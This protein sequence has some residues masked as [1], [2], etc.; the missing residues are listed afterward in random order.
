EIQF[1]DS[2]YGVNE[3]IPGYVRVTVLY[4][5][6]ATA[7]VSVEYYTGD[8]SASTDNGD[9]LAAS[10]TLIFDVGETSKTFD[11]Q[12]ID[13]PAADGNRFFTVGLRSPDGAGL[14]VFS[15]SI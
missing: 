2:S 13:N 5:G 15:S 1:S 7:P 8:G 10:G 9:Y 4:G 11:V 6:G 12:I 14:N 3:N